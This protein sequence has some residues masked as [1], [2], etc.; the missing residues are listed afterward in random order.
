MLLVPIHNNNNNNTKSVVFELLCNNSAWIS[1]LFYLDHEFFTVI[2][3]VT[4]NW[5]ISG[6]FQTKW[7]QIFLYQ[8]AIYWPLQVIMGAHWVNVHAMSF[9]STDSIYNK[10]KRKLT[11][12]KHCHCNYWAN[13]NVY[14]CLIEWT[15]TNKWTS[16]I[17]S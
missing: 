14:R 16:F 7:R 4:D 10:I 2:N 5:P 6:N 12:A 13:F 1:M 9:T 11:M 17:I 8:F 3:S 15:T